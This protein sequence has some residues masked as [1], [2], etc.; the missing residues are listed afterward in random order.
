MLVQPPMAGHDVMVPWLCLFY[1]FLINNE[2]IVGKKN[3]IRPWHHE[4]LGSKAAVARGALMGR[5]PYPLSSLL[6]DWWSADFMQDSLIVTDLRFS[7]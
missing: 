6:L 2:A 7:P 1:S 5:V 4:S 3:A